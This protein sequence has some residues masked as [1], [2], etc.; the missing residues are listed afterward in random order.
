MK[1][2]SEKNPN[3]Y[4]FGCQSDPDTVAKFNYIGFTCALL[5]SAL[6]AQFH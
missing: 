3:Y 1:Y 4:G 6:R 2:G 5:A